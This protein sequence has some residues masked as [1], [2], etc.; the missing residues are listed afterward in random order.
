MISMTGYGRSEFCDEKLTLSIEIKSYNNRYLDVYMHM[1]S[2]L[3]PLEEEIRRR[4]QQSARRGK[5]ELYVYLKR[6]K[7]TARVEVDM[8]LLDG[9]VQAFSEIAD[10]HPLSD[11]AAGF[12]TGK[13]RPEVL[14]QIDN[15]FSVEKNRDISDMQDLLME[16][17]DSALQQW[18]ASRQR[19]GETA[20]AD[21]RAQLSRIVAGH[22]SVALLAPQLEER[23]R[24]SLL[25]RFQEMLGQQIDEQRVYAE[26]A[27][28][29]VKYS[30]S[31]ELSRLQAHLVECERLLESVQ[32]VGKRMDFLCQ[33]IN[34]EINTI[35]SK[36]SVLDM[37]RA[38][39]DMKDALEN[40]REQLR[41]VE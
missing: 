19:E 32:A 33:E 16:T 25:E 11:G 38:V 29:L 10:R 4:V 30:V 7:E 3:N 22:E 6:S 2:V 5:I 28:L 34:R 40:I 27:V 9:Y 21:I 1:P 15:L 41:N 26:T 37:S 13:I 12:S 14:L 8:G 23:I 35:G 36:S 20:C 31:E 18:Q 24:E 17:L 39:I